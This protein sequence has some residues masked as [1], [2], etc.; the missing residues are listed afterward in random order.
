M[1]STL[2]NVFLILGSLFLLACSSSSAIQA[3]VPE[4]WSLLET[5][6]IDMHVQN[7]ANVNESMYILDFKSTNDETDIWA[8]YQASD[9]PVAIEEFEE[10]TVDGMPALR[11]EEQN[12]YYILGEGHYYMVNTC[13][14]KACSS[15]DE[16]IFT[17]FVESIN[18]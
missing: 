9:F 4:G 16:T 11:H 14:S 17:D 13:Q 7:D 5:E 3:A 1:K 8:W 12:L 2:H 10:I 15:V 6:G 18:L